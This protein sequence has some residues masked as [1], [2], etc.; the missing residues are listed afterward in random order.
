MGVDESSQRIA[1][2]VTILDHQIVA[3][4]Q[5]RVKLLQHRRDV[6]M[7]I[8]HDQQGMG[9]RAQQLG[10]KQVRRIGAVALIKVDLR[11]LRGGPDQ[12]DGMDAP[13]DAKQC[14]VVGAALAPEPEPTSN[15]VCGRSSA[16]S[17]G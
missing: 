4:L 2:H 10:S 5:E 11:V 8:L 13:F 7:R 12:I 17:A 3:R 6:V 1:F 15:T 16:I 14:Q 9:R